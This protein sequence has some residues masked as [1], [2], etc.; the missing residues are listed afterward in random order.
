MT[1]GR[2][3]RTAVAVSDSHATKREKLVTRDNFRAD[4]ARN[5]EADRRFFGCK[6]KKEK[7]SVLAARLQRQRWTRAVGGR[8]EIPRLWPSTDLFENEVRRCQTGRVRWYWPVCV[9]KIITIDIS[10]GLARRT[11]VQ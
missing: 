7:R 11:D 3:L 4:L 10:F 2:P 5:N 6:K 9:E 8:V 1:V